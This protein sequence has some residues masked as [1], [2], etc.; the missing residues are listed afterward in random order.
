MDEEKRTEKSL[1]EK[2]AAALEQLRSAMPGLEIYENEPMNTHC[3]FRTGG[4]ARALLVPQSIMSLSKICAI[5]KENE[6]A[7]Y[8]LGNG[9]NV[10]FPDEGESEL[11]V[12]STEKLQN[13]FLTPDGAIYAEA[14]VPLAKLAAF[15]LEN[16]LTGLEFASG[17]P[18]TVGGGMI[19]NAGA[20]GGEMKDAVESVVCYYLPDQGLYEFNREECAFG[21]RTSRFQ[22]VGG[23]IVLSAVF[24]LA[25]G[26]RNEI[27]GKMKELNGRRREKQPLDMP[28]AG[29]AFKRPE[30]H[31]AAA[32]I[33]EAGLKGSRIG[34][35]QV[36]EKHAG[37][38]VNTGSAT[39]RD[40]YELMMHVRRTVWE[41]TAVELKPEIIL[42]APG[43]KLEDH[44]P[45][46]RGN[47]L[48][49]PEE[50][51][52]GKQ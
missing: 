18:G 29:S 19:M 20:Y 47:I 44:G 8:M 27:S 22:T 4:P 39:S 26:D 16:G 48:N 36:S 6:L 28:S 42:L 12:V 35:A 46:I 40:L 49:G 11:I 37:F 30:G 43:Y 1:E 2:I 31:Y 9:T 23:F 10:V 15:A 17:I 25:E 52:R 13:L 51:G 5:L 3:S 33:E 41:K 32:L 45:K 21:Y 34:G 38:I 14:G 50:S 7:P 24:R